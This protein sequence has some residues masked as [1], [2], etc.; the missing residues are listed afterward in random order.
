MK[1]MGAVG[2][3]SGDSEVIQS[4]VKSLGRLVNALP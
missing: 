4:V 3:A 1:E 2:G